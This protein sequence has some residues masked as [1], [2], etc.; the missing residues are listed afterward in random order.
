MTMTSRALIC[1]FA[2]A[3]FISPAPANDSA[4]LPRGEGWL[5]KSY[6]DV[7]PS[8][9]RQNG[10]NEQAALKAI[11]AKRTAADVARIRWWATGGPAYRWNEIVLDELQENFVT[12]PL[13][14]RHLALFHVAVD[15]AVAAAAY[16][17]GAANRSEEIDA[18]LRAAPRGSSS[19]SQHAAAATAA[20]AVLGYLFP[21]RAEKFSAMAEEVMQMRLT[22]GMEYPSD[23][24]AGRM[25]GERVAA[26]AIARGRADRSDAKWSGSVP[27]GHDRWQG[28]NP[29]APMAGT[30]QPWV[31]SHASEFRPAPPP[32]AD[33][34]ETASALKELKLFART[35]KSNH[36]AVFWE[37]NGGARAH[38]LWNEIARMKLLE[39]GETSAMASRVLAAVNIALIDAGIACWDAKYTFWYVR[40]TQLDPELKSVFPPP[41]HPSYP[42]AHGCF[43]TAAATVLAAVF[44]GDRDRLLAL[45]KEASEAR[46]WAGIHYRF[47]IDAGQEIG[48]RVAERTLER[49]FSARTH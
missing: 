18:A 43:S 31:L 14:A 2:T 35:P 26:L 33:S 34:N 7:Q 19:P 10:R 16:S 47:D 44:P 13:S 12:L 17:Q 49:A 27:Q 3:L 37:V 6:R 29:I 25:I 36:R 42:A 20:A 8:A 30:W 21:A 28:T 48:R 39:H 40:P 15:D 22:G 24:S 45:G 38:T 32:A 4:P 11:T 1:A 5:V 9:T 46:I 41:N 23:V